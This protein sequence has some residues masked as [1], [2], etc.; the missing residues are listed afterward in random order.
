MS[1]DFKVKDINQADFGR[2][3]ISLAE[4]EMPGLIALRKSCNVHILLFRLSLEQQALVLLSSEETLNCVGRS[5]SLNLTLST[6]FDVND[7]NLGDIRHGKPRT[8]LR[9]HALMRL[10]L[11]MHQENLAIGQEFL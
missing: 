8:F 10:F 5:I 7:L 3:E 4:T 1:Q 6:H 9:D 11:P 2:K